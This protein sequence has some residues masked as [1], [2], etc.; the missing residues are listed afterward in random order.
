MKLQLNGIEIEVPGD[1][2]VDVSED[3]KRVTIKTAE[4]KVVEKIRVVEVPSENETIRYI[5]G[6]E[7]IRFI[8]VEK[9]CTRPHN[10]HW[11]Y[12]TPYTSPTTAPSWPISTPIWSSGTSTITVS[13][14][15]NQAWTVYQGDLN[16][17]LLSNVQSGLTTSNAQTISSNISIT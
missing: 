9:P 5:P 2:Q 15:P 11:I 4:P 16:G 8:E 13:G 3:G 7:T 6:P 1:A 14:D 10:D 17:G 12:T